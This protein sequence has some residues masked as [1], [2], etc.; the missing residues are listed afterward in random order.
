MSAMLKISALRQPA[1]TQSYGESEGY[2]QPSGSKRGGQIPVR[3][4]YRPVGDQ[5][6]EVRGQRTAEKKSTLN[7]QPSTLRIA[8]LTGGGDKPYALGVA[9]ALTSQ[10]IFVDFIGSDELSVPAVLNNSRVTFLNLRGNQRADASPFSKAWRVLKYYVHLISY[11]ATAQPKLFHLL[12][13][14]KFELF[15]RTLLMLYYR[16]LGKK[17]TLTVHNVN[18]RKRDSNDSFLNRLS[19]RIQ[20]S[21]CDHIFVHTERM[22]SELVSDFRIPM[23]KVSV[24][25]FGINNTVPNTALSTDEAKQQIGVNSGDK[26]LLFFGNITPY[27]GL[28]CLISAFDVLLSKDRSYR[29]IIAGRPKGSETYWK[30]IQ[31]AIARGGISDRII[32]RIEYIPDELTELYF[33][34]ADALIL[35]Y[36]HVF[37]SGVL[38]L[39]YSFGLPA[40]AA[41]VGALKEEIIE[42]ETGF[43]FEPGDS[44]DLAREIDN[45]F[46]SELFGDL[47]NRRKQIRE[48]ANE[49]YS[50]DKVATMTMAVY[51]SLLS[52]G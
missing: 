15:D 43:I 26:A 23:S 12:W 33:K 22:R 36:T 1:F 37:Q 50:W 38:F 29:L 7:T 14:N 32:Q 49:R 28:E 46:N 10:G 3:R 34:A 17:I 40:I 48:H 24:I 42:G 35:P 41:D 11:A 5:M 8:L 45:Y 16:L 18:A 27:K 52:S 20:Y 4:T 6:S 39:G 13:N 51:S 21:F 9:A 44:V 30:E 47:E 25:P 2:V 31:Q 19:L